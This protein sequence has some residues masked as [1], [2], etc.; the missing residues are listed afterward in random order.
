MI[1]VPGRWTVAAAVA[2][3]VVVGWVQP[4]SAEST[5]STIGIVVM[6]GKGGMPKG[7]VGELAST[8]E[9]KGF[10][11][12]NIEMPWSK[13]RQYDV[14]VSTADKAVMSALD[15]LRGKGATHV[16][17]A[18]HSQGGVYALQFGGK[19]TVNGIIAI[20]PG[21][22]VASEFFRDKLGATVA[23]AR[24]LVAEGKVSERTKFYDFEGSK[25]AIPVTTTPTIYLT[26]FDPD[27]AMNQ[28]SAVKTMN[29]KV[30]VLYI[31]PT[32]D[33]P[34]LRKVKQ[35]MFGAL[36]SHPL[37]KLYEPNANHINAPTAS[38]GEIARWV[39]DVASKAGAARNP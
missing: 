37:T 19:H 11:V 25:G 2:V 24:A 8:L 32:S 20:A 29:P 21:G 18:G 39:T 5:P 30:P 10:L 22:N 9:E 15:R 26:W 27:G 4:V 12:A 28:W 17:V 3:S 6:H 14:D 38:I 35:E 16:F 31:V 23:E 1:R 13:R 33:Y 34:A 36:P 7:L